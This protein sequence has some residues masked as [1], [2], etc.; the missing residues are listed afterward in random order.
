MH[1]LGPPITTL[2]ADAF[3]PD[4][5]DDAVARYLDLYLDH[6]VALTEALPGAADALDAVHHHGGRVIV[7]TAKHPRTATP[8]LE[9]AGLRVDAVHGSRYGADKQATL[10]AEG[11]AM[12]VGDTPSDIAAALAAGCVAI[13]VAS[14]PASADTLT[15]CGAHHV[16]GSL[17]EFPAVFADWHRGHPAAGRPAGG[18]APG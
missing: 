9:Q 2:L 15:G 12:Y 10:T 4:E 18:E 16:L 3:A 6:G 13:G 17:V 8:C 1:H 5:I 14:G 7:I 11:A